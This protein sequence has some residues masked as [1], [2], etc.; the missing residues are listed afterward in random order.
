MQVKGAGAQSAPIPANTIP[1]CGAKGIFAR[2]RICPFGSALGYVARK[3]TL[4][5]K[6]GPMWGQPPELDYVNTFESIKKGHISRNCVAFKLI[7]IFYILAVF[8]ITI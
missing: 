8:L 6:K 3:T 4:T 1:Q 7:M 5:A 2:A